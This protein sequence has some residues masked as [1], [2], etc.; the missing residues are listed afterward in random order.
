MLSER[1]KNTINYFYRL[2][3]L[4]EVCP[5]DTTDD[6]EKKKELYEHAAKWLYAELGIKIY[7]Q[8]YSYDGKDYDK[9]EILSDVSRKARDRRRMLKNMNLEILEEKLFG[10]DRNNE[11]FYNEIQDF[12]S[13]TYNIPDMN[14][15]P[16]YTSCE[17]IDNVLKKL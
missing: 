8:D 11:E 10:R 2:L 5:N 3:E 15:S 7:M 4:T 1:D 9:Y 14:I 12:I 6:I 16:R 13:I 17:I